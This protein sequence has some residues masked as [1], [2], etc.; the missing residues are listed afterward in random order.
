MKNKTATIA[1]FSGLALG[2]L[3]LRSC[4]QLPVQ[5][6]TFLVVDQDG[7]PVPGAEVKVG[8]DGLPKKTEHGLVPSQEVVITGQSGSVSVEGGNSTGYSAFDVSKPGYYG[9]SSEWKAHG[10]TNRRWEPWNPTFKLEIK[11]IRNPIPMYAFSARAS[12]KLWK[13]DFPEALPA[14]P[15]SFDLLAHDWVEPHGKGRVPDITLSMEEPVEPKGFQ[16]L[17]MRFLNPQDGITA[18]TV[19]EGRCA[20]K[21]SHLAPVNGYQ[22]E[23]RFDNLQRRQILTPN[24]VDTT[25]SWLAFRI[26]TR[27]G[28][29]GEIESAHF[30]KIYEYPDVLKLPKVATLTRLCYYV[31]PTPNSRNLEWD[32]KT[33]LF[34]DLDELN[35]PEHP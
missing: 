13:F 8:F 9:V 35:W 4:A 28:S 7:K 6:A 31:N 24:K 29:D 19:N 15:V 10:V 23:M 14:G 30:G 21:S 5:K 33:N 27:L 17:V 2:R 16:V 22:T 26:R 20:L 34:T 1:I 25:E 32:K 18:P 12:S 11:E 3:G